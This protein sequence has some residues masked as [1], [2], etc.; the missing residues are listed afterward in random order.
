MRET[1]VVVVGAGLA[2]LVAAREVL[3]AGRQAIVIEA[4][5]RVGGRL[6]NEP[7]GADHPGKVVEVGG[8][9][10][11]PTQT[12]LLELASEL[13]VETFPTY[14]EGENILEWRGGL[15]RYT[16]AIPRINPAILLDTLQ[17]QKRLER[18]ART[19]PVEAPWA[20]PRARRLDA[21][22]FQTW[23]DRACRTRGARTLMELATQAVWAAEPADVSLLHVLFYI[24]SAGSFDDLVGTSGGAQER[25]FAGGSQRLA[26]RL[27]EELPE[28]TI[29]LGA[30]VRRIEH[31]DDGVTVRADGDVTVRAGRAIVALPPTLT[32][33]MI[34]SPPLPGYRD[35]ATQR[36]PQGTVW[37]CMA[38]YDRPFWREQGLTGQATSDRGPVRVT[39]DNSPP[40]GSPG[41]LLGFLEGDFARRAC[42]QTAT[43]R[44][45]EVLD[46]FGRFFG[47]AARS[48]Q[49][50]IEQSWAEE[51]FTRGCYGC[52]MTPGA[53]T[54]FGE[55]LRAPVGPIHWA[56]AEVATR[57]SGYMDG[58]VRSGREA[59]AAAVAALRPARA[60]TAAP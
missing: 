40:D 35:Q 32:N 57:W 51:E 24:N 4:R 12:A 31:G 10:V 28:G 26:L 3:R 8:Q 53:W 6:L 46:C 14:D 60:V 45:A 11:G 29:V 38:V 44:R 17:A 9:W 41:V 23:L 2:G 18:L 42:R 55:A 56:G 39:F 49:R 19:V 58:A 20:A 33:R 25:R 50:Y 5:E 13:G 30:P 34:Y 36:M 7:L 59:A 1:D 27:A 37:K 21:M 54:S 43:D 15:Q 52:G 47:D 22:T 16:G 48:P